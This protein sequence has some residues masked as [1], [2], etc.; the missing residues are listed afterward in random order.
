VNIY[1]FEHRHT[2]LK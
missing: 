1:V 2:L